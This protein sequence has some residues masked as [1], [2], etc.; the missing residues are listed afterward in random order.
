MSDIVVIGAGHVGLTLLADLELTKP[1]HGFDARLLSLESA[2]AL[3]ERSR[4]WTHLVMEN[5][6]TGAVETCSLSESQFASLW[7]DEG[8]QALNTAGTIVV[9][10]PDIPHLRLDLLDLLER[11]VNLRGK[12]LVFVRGG[13]GGQPVLAKWLRDSP[14]LRDTSVVLVEDSFYGTRVTG[15]TVQ[16]KRKISVNVAIYSRDREDALRALRRMF[17]LGERIGRPSWP[18]MRVC[19]GIDLL[20]SPLGYIIHVGVALDPGNVE[21]TRRGIS[22]S[23]SSGSLDELRVSRVLMEDVPAFLTIRWLAGRAGV[24]MPHTQAYFNDVTAGL[25]EIGSDFR[26]YTTYLPYLEKI[27]DD[28]EGLR[29]LLNEPLLTAAALSAP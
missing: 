10:V 7:S 20:F 8:R 25:R 23:L 9:T 22:R 14:G 28:G 2:A 29:Q 17:P 26:S 4:D 1:H 12:L 18:D 5:L 3:K 13:Q 15:R 27:D 24:D 6:V 16:Y 21:K 11:S 19:D